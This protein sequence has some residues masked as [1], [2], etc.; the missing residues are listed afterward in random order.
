[1]ADFVVPVVRECLTRLLIHEAN[2]LDGVKDQV[3]LLQGDLGIMNAFLRNSEG[4]QSNHPL[5]IE[6][7]DQ[8][9]DVALEAQNVLDKYVASA[10]K[11]RRRRLLAKFIHSIIHVKF[12]HDVARK[13]ASIKRGITNIYDRR[14]AYGIGE[15]ES[16]Y[17]DAEAEQSLQTR[18]RNVE[19]D[20][21]VGFDSDATSLVKQLTNPQDL[22]LDVI[23]IVGMGGLG[24]TTLARK[25]YNNSLVTNSFRCRAW[26]YGSEDCKTQEWLLGIIRGVMQVTVEMY[27]MNNEALKAILRHRLQGERYLVVMDDLWRAQIWDEVCSAFPDDLNGSRILITSRIHEVALNASATTPPF[28]L[29]FLGEEESWELFQK[30]VFRGGYCPS[31]L[32]DIGRK[33]AEK[34]KGLP[35]SIVVLGSLLATKEKS[36]RTWSRFIDNVNWYLTEDKTRCLDILALSYNHLPRHLKICY[37]YVGGFP[38]DYEIPARLLIN[39]WS[40]EGFIEQ[41]G[42]RYVDD[43]AEDYLEQLIDRSLI[44]V[45]SKRSDGGVKTCRIHDLLRDIC[46]KESSRAKFIEVH[47]YADLSSMTMKSKPHRLSIMNCNMNRYISSN[48]CDPSFTRSL[49]MFSK[50]GCLYAG[51][52]RWVYKGFKFIRV[53]HIEFVYSK[54][55]PSEIGKLIHLRCFRICNKGEE[56]IKFIPASICNL[57]YLETIHIGGCASELL[58]K[59]IWM[60]KQLKCLNLK[61]GMRLPE[62]PRK[63]DGP[64]WNLQVV[65]R[66]EVTRKTARLFAKFPNV[67]K[68]Y[69]EFQTMGTDRNVITELLQELEHLQYLQTLKIRNFITE[70]ELLLKF[71]PARLTKITFVFSN[72]YRR[73]FKILGQ[74]PNLRVLKLRD[75]DELYHLKFL[76]GAFPQLEF[77]GM[78]DLQGIETWELERGAMPNLGRLVICNCFALKDLPN[79]LWD[80]TSLQIVKVSRVSGDLENRVKNLSMRNQVKL[81]ID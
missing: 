81:L 48:I 16:S 12:L 33:L 80:L 2:L 67:R 39:L 75:A 17:V 31:N 41:N 58:P 79:Q 46:M 78:K 59:N 21:V 10:I 15:A 19:E 47:S 72:L 65:S 34:C 68:L 56:M 63:M 76:A 26:V 52:W 35:L 73:H 3:K 22:K 32:E 77:F 55:I 1:M 30:K 36:Y 37:L 4:K 53:L 62:P 28:F 43:V 64:L 7:V 44:Q 6:I 66:L 57:L 70:S 8:I 20:D 14:Q 25:I 40:S 45:A 11:Q 27:E 51:Q 5:V 60:M 23:S 49:L 13:T 50:E 18:R 9:R 74:L 69:L 71:F 38:E 24:K 29:P 54:E 42:N 61:D